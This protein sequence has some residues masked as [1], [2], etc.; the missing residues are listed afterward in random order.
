MSRL[1]LALTSC[2]L[3]ALMCCCALSKAEEPPR[4][5]RLPPPENVSSDL[6][7][8]KADDSVTPVQ[9]SDTGVGPDSVAD[10]D[11][12]DEL[13]PGTEME[14]ESDFLDL[15]LAET[16]GP[17]FELDGNEE[18]VDARLD[19][20]F[21]NFPE[22]TGGIVVFG[23]DVALKIGGYIKADLIKDFDAI[24]S[25]DVFDTTT[26]PTSGPNRQNA[27]FHARQSRLSFDTRWRTEGETVRAFVEGDFFG[28]EPNNPTFRLRHAYGR[29]GRFT[30]GQ[31]WT[32]FTDP[33]AVPQ[34]LDREGGVSNVN[35]R[36]G[37]VRW[38]QPLWCDDL[39][40]AMA[41]EDPEINV[42]AASMLM[43]QGRTEFPDFITRIRYQ[44][45]WGELR[46]AYVLRT[47]GFQPIGEPV[48]NENGWG[49]NFT[50]AVFVLEDTK[51]YYQITFGDGIGSYRGSPD[52]VA[53]GPNS[54]EVV[55][56][57]GWM[58]GVHQ[59][60]NDSLTSNL[61]F[62]R[63]HMEDIPGQDPDNLRSTTYLA[64]NLISNPYERVFYGIEYLYG[65]REDASGARGDANRLQLSFGF[66]LP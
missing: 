37:L 18:G 30:A 5:R 52:V 12:D 32:T 64:V 56:S 60:W 8:R 35:R 20:N 63:L 40:F 53:T 66:F 44:R 15:S 29:L 9:F 34:T 45:D 28:G 21:T 7:A 3:C 31:T 2:V 23:D 58:V 47:L 61:T 17:S 14:E 4:P 39:S 38:D 50:G 57:F 62:S 13:Y 33:S 26:I 25:T 48:I 43:G 6:P 51:A 1:Q 27:R 19:N 49:F 36:Q 11:A 46:G 24:G 55:G 22:F 65:V 10:S 59:Q 42:E 54:A 41:L 16:V